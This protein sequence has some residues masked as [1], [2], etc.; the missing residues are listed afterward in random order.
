M[1]TYTCIDTKGGLRMK[2]IKLLKEVLDYIE[3]HLNEGLTLEELAELHYIS[4]SHLH[5]MFSAMCSYSPNRGDR[6]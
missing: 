6:Q 5:K 1:L 3:E 2:G 4:L